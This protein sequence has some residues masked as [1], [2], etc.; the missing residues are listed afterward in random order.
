MSQIIAKWYKIVGEESFPCINRPFLQPFSQNSITQIF[1]SVFLAAKKCFL[2]LHPPI[3]HFLPQLQLLPFCFLQRQQ[4]FIVFSSWSNCCKPV[5][6]SKNIFE[7]MEGSMGLGFVAVFVVSGS[8]AFVARQ[9]HN[10]LL[11]EFMQKIE[12]EMCGKFPFSFSFFFLTS[13]FFNV[14]LKIML[15][16]IVGSEKCQEKK[17]VRFADDVI[18]PSSNNKEYRKRTLEKSRRKLSEKL[19]C[20]VWISHNYM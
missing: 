12:Y 10:R 14:I 8:V 9:A 5:L 17:K 1:V 13:L 3:I 15:T 7:K 19:S 11:S 4:I 2:S 18:E 6:F 16:W 20:V